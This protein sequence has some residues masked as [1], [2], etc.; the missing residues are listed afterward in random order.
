M[1][2]TDPDSGMFYKT[3]KEK[4]FAYTAHTACDSNGMVLGVK[5]TSGNI[6]D[7]VMFK[8]LYEDICERITTPDFI[9]ADA[10]YK[11]TA[12]SHY[13][14]ATETQLVIPYRNK[15]K[16]KSAYRKSN[17]IYDKTEETYTCPEDNVMRPT[18]VNSEGQIVFRCKRGVC[19]K[20]P[21]KTECFSKSYSSRAVTR[22]IWADAQDADDEFRKTSDGKFYYSGRKETVERVFA[23][24]KEQHGM[25]YTRLRG[26]EKVTEEVYLL[27]GCMN[28]KK[29]MKRMERM[30]A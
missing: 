8:P 23:D 2:N 11:S 5:V 15:N 1:S 29:M 30:M 22:H 20:C 19:N 24:G 16:S 9:V 21:K 10:G 17:F 25:R 6:H 13:F 26:I 12:I 14:E 28:L 18:T 4:G 7:I 3:N 27:F